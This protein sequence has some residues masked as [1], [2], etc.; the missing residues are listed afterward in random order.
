MEIRSPKRDGIDTSFMEKISQLT[1]N[2]DSKNILYTIE[3]AT[4]EI[5]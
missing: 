2:D 4:I 1:S 5:E 3:A